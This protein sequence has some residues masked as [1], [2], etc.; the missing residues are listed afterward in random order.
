MDRYFHGQ[1]ASFESHSERLHPGWG[2]NL[3]IAWPA[4]PYREQLLQ[5]SIACNRQTQ[6]KY[7]IAYYLQQKA[8]EEQLLWEMSWTD[9]I[10]SS[11][12][13]GQG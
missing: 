9:T 13:L 1:S 3:I 11:S 7:A 6:I 2:T 12:A 5:T 4:L 10:S 8:P